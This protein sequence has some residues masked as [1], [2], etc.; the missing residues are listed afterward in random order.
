MSVKQYLNN[1]KTQDIYSLML[2]TLYKCKD[3]PEYSTLS[4]L[5]YVLDESNLL[6]LCECFGGMTLKIPTIQELEDLIYTLN[7]YKET[8]ID[9]T[10]LEDALLKLELPENDLCNIKHIYSQLLHIMEEFKFG[11]N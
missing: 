10:S 9:K 11:T 3:M 1:L 5:A 7:I 6:N 8:H 2:F 4:E